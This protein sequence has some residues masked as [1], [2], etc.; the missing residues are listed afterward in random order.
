MKKILC[1]FGML[2][3]LASCNNIDEVKPVNKSSEQGVNNEILNRLI[4]KYNLKVGD[5]LNTDK[6]FKSLK[7]FEN[8][9]DLEIFLDDKNSIYESM[10]GKEF[11]HEV[12]IKK[13]TIQRIKIE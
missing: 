4:S 5:D 1:L 13:V 12:N 9:S 3:I 11:E 2:S 10:I 8:L 7:K 6:K